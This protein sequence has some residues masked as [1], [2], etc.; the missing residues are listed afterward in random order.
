VGQ[1]LSPKAASA[2]KIMTSNIQVVDIHDSYNMAFS[3][4]ATLG[5]YSIPVTKAGKLLGLLEFGE[6][7]RLKGVKNGA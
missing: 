6:A 5:T 2:E 1:E 4:M 7:M 3:I